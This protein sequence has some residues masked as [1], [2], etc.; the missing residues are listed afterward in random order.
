M[1]KMSYDI[2][3]TA[4]QEAI[5]REHEAA[6]RSQAVEQYLLNELSQEKRT[7]FEAHYFECP[8]CADAI[9]AGQTFLTHVRPGP[10]V[11]RV[12][13]QQPAAAIAALFLAVAGGQQLVIAQLSAPHANSVILARQLEKGAGETPYIVRT[14]S[15]TVEVNLAGETRYPFYRVKIGGGQGRKLWQVVPAPLEGSE[16]RLS[17][18]V[19][20]RSL[21]V[22]HFTVDVEGLDRE[23]S[24]SGPRIGEAY[25]FDL[26]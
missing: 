4:R 13:W 17:V 3:P 21:G 20:R 5:R 19:S 8:E 11:R 12:W 15:A 16:Q 22:G 26:K 18:Q 10:P 1:N 23:D 6:M 7:Q 9:E 24:K 14:P 2:H 25:E